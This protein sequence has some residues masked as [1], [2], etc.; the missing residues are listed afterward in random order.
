M[1]QFN[2]ATG[3]LTCAA[4]ILPTDGVKR[5]RHE[6]SESYPDGNAQRNPKREVAFE[7]LHRRLVN[8]RGQNARSGAN[9]PPGVLK[10]VVW[11]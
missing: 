8:L 5:S 9:P 10:F 3:R 1:N 6:V 7:R 4:S 2:T 11:P